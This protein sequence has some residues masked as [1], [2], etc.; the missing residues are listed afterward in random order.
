MEGYNLLLPL[1]ERFPIGDISFI[2]FPPG[3]CYKTGRLVIYHH[4]F[5]PSVG[6]TLCVKCF[7]NKKYAINAYYSG[8]LC[9]IEYFIAI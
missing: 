3:S 7:Q 2:A 9:V 5:H 6:P 4:L 8:G 1:D